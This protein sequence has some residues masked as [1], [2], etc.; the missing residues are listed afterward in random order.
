MNLTVDASVFVAASRSDE[1]HYRVEWMVA[2]PAA[3]SG[4]KAGLP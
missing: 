2:Q 4:E 1:V 3:E